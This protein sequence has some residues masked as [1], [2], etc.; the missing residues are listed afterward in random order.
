MIVKM[1]TTFNCLNMMVEKENLDV[2]KDSLVTDSLEGDI[3]LYEK[4]YDS[5]TSLNNEIERANIK[6]KII[7]REIDTINKKKYL[8]DRMAL[9][10]KNK[11]KTKERNPVTGVWEF[12]E[13]FPITTIS[14][15]EKSKKLEQKKFKL[16][17][18]LSA[19]N[20]STKIAFE[21]DD[22]IANSLYG[23]NTSEDGQSIE[24]LADKILD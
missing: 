20:A 12:R 7:L 6:G 9:G 19:F 15:E 5:L 2:H 21:L 23:E 11:T 8:Y 16:E 24:E 10:L 4:L 22:Y 17:D 14:F 3:E 13:Y 1:T 18:E